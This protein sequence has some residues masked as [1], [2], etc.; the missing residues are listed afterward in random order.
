MRIRV[1][2]FLYSVLFLAGQASGGSIVIPAW[3]FDR[4]NV[5]IDANPA[6]Y[7][8]AGPVVVSGP[9]APWGWSVEYD[10][11]IPVE[12]NYS[13]QVCY[14]S[15]D[16][17]P[18][19]VYIDRKNITKLGQTIT[20]DPKSSGQPDQFSGN[21]SAARWE[22]A[23]NIWG[24]LLSIKLT[25]GSHT[26]K[27]MRRGPLPHL[28]A[29]RADSKT[30]F[31][32]NWKPAQYRVGDIQSVP[33]KFRNA[34]PPAKISRAVVLQREIKR[35]I[36]LYG[37]RYPQGPLHLNQAA[38][39]EKKPNDKALTA[40]HHQVSAFWIKEVPKKRRGPEL[41]IPA[42][43]F[44]RGNVKIYASPDLFA[45]HGPLIASDPKQ[46]GPSVV[47]YDIDF[48]VTGE[49]ILKVLSVSA[50]A[51]PMEVFVDD[52]SMGK[53]CYDISYGSAPFEI[54]V[55]F[56]GKSSARKDRKYTPLKKWDAPRTLSI[57][58][59]KHTI[60]FLRNGALPH[61]LEFKMES[62][63]S[64]PKGW[65][66]A[67]REMPHLDSVPVRDQSVFLAADS[68]NMGALR[69]SIE[70]RIK[71]LGSAYP[72]GP[73]FLKRLEEFEKKKSTLRVCSLL[74]GKNTTTRTWESEE[75]M[76]EQQ[77]TMEKKL[78]A[79]RRDA[80]LADPAM[81]FDKLLFFKRKTYPGNVYMDN[82]M[83]SPGGSI[84]VLSPVS[85]EGKV[86][87]L[88]PELDGGIFTRFDLSFD[89]T[90]MVFGYKK[91]DERFRL[92]EIDVDPAKGIMVPGSLR[93]LT[94]DS[95]DEAKA[96]AEV[97]ELYKGWHE[98]GFHFDDM[99]PCYLPNGKIIFS[100]TR[101]MRCVFC[102]PATVATLYVV[103]GD[104]KNMRC[105]SAGPL[106]ESDP[107]VLDDGRVVFTRW[108]YIDKGLGNGQSIWAIRPDGSG[109]DHIYKNTTVRPA[110]ML[111][112]RSIP[113]SRK[114]ITVGSPHSGGRLGGPVILIDNRATRR[115][116]EAMEC[117]TPEVSYPCGYPGR[118]DM[119]FFREPYP[120]SEKLYLVSH[121][122][123]VRGKSNPYGIYVLDKW[124]NRTK[125]H[126]DPTLSSHQPVP[127]RPRLTPLQI[128]PIHSNHA[129]KKTGTLFVQDVY[130]GMTGIKRGRVKY[131]RVMGA[132]PWPWNEKGIFRLSAHGTVHRK[133][134]YGI[135]TV[136]KD[137]SAA[138][139]APAGENLFFQALDENYMQL[140]H[141]PTFI[142][143][144]PGEKRSCVGCHE[145]RRKAPSANRARPMAM[146][147]PVEKLKNQPGDTGPDTIHYVRDIQPILDKNCVSC[148]G[149]KNPAGKLNLTGEWTDYWTR[150]Y[151]EIT[152]KGL[153][154]TRN[155]GYGRSGFY[156]RPP[157]NFGS[158]LSKLA[159]QIQKDPC[160][161]KLTKEEFIKIVTWIDANS[162][163]L[164]IYGERG[165]KKN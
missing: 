44:D 130:Q 114:L 46:T 108:E 103:D 60:K 95:E 22:G 17:R 157:L 68:V 86:T 161:G 139:T 143:L 35:M 137:G 45:D 125:L 20:L 107:C 105:L 25:K 5:V 42:W 129:N 150:S 57:T 144:R 147:H 15:P 116:A 120:F 123:G 66:Q 159:K 97:K 34:L 145:K 29:L 96:L 50:K 146:G 54:P 16:A 58:K 90:K 47:E 81:K 82:K 92:Y 110:Q 39:L 112:T 65:T 64:F 76:P 21:S 70:D 59:G 85:P 156:A 11:D 152:G 14:A 78:S 141:M 153:V 2:L 122:V 55:H 63:E 23:R 164:G 56:S 12:G 41:V 6:G 51:R 98:R 73:K 28:V 3:A 163:F 89:A 37:P 91:K 132:L 8:D 26:L 121:L 33:E 9:K 36:R 77:R 162:P 88:I 158:H 27:L 71:T 43:T 75:G 49:Y 149:K 99:D 67:L 87:R 109:V 106:S 94:F 111:N 119:G 7:A 13:F 24:R 165:G 10:I 100:S 69:Q 126:H 154:S 142:N 93:Q 136:H 101:S 32:A 160:K 83:N 151:E 135:A 19:Q 80:L 128:A 134:V 40:L 127:L 104:G 53:I 38:A 52:K 115:S 72:E 124:G 62:A 140:Q 133:K 31:P 117:I 48:P 1:E 84:C 148:H 4:G 155:S 30:E 118:W 102:H 61:I 18:V 131:I 74:G 79:L 138:F 113:G